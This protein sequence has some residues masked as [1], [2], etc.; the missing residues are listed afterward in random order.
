MTLADAANTVS[1]AAAESVSGVSEP[2]G[3]AVER[4]V[5]AG[6]AL[7]LPVLWGLAVHL[8]FN[9]LTRRRSVTPL[10]DPVIQDYQI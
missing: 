4:I 1:K 8:V 9:W 10:E 6:A 5:L 7:V 3:D 2:S